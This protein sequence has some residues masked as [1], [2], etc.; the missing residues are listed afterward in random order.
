MTAYSYGLSK[1]LKEQFREPE[2]LSFLVHEQPLVKLTGSYKPANKTTGFLLHYLAGAGFS[3]GYEYL[4]KPAVK[5]PTV[6]KGAA[7]GVLA[8]LTGVAIWEATIRLRE[9][10]PRLNK[11]KYYTHLVLAH[12][13]YGVTTA[14]ASRAMSKTEG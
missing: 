11:G 7:Y 10:P 8:G 4:W 3:A 5:L 1:T 6:L 12:V 13:V 2:F 14:L 9:T